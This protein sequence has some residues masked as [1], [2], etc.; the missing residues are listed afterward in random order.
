MLTC[1]V[2]ASAQYF[3][4]NATTGA[5]MVLIDACYLV[6]IYLIERFGNKKYNF[7]AVIVAGVGV[8]LTCAFTWSG[9]VSL[10]PMFAILS[11][12]VSVEF[13]NVVYSKTGAAIRNCLNIAYLFLISSYLGAGLECLLLISAIVGIILSIKKQKKEKLKNTEKEQKLTDNNLDEV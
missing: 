11:F 8:V 10:L 12:L 4:L 1:D 9:A 3:L 7:I 6:A 13:T 2:L 5:V